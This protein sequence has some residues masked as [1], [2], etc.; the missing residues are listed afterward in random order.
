MPQRARR[1]I[2]KS[3][4]ARM[5]ANPTTDYGAV[6]RRRHGPMVLESVPA[7]KTQRQDRVRAIAVDDP[8][9]IYRRNRVISVL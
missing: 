4:T 8:L 1:K 9:Y 5:L 3:K 7:G 2:R 6:E